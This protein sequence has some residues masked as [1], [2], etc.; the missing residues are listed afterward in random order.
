MMLFSVNCVRPVP[1][2][3]RDKS[4]AI[5]MDARDLARR[6]MRTKAFLKS[7]VRSGASAE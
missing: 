7:R 3:R 5:F 1:T 4:P 6:L 2:C